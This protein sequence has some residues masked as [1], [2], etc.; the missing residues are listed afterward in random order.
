MTAYVDS[1]LLMPNGR[2]RKGFIGSISGQSQSK[3]LTVQ[4]WKNQ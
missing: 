2:I 3:N 1:L 4:L